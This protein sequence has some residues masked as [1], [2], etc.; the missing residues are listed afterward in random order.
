MQNLDVVSTLLRGQNAVRSFGVA[1]L[2]ACCALPASAQTSDVTPPILVNFSFAPTS[3]DVS[4][5]AQTVA[6]TMQVTDDLSGVSSVSV[7]FRSPNGLQTLSGFAT[8]TAGTAFD[9]VWVANVVIPPFSEAG[10]WTVF[11]VFVQDRVGNSSSANAAVLNSR[12]FPTLLLVNSISDT[13]APAVVGIAVAPVGADVSLADQPIQIG[14]QVTDN[15][16]GVTFAPCTASQSFNF[17]AVILQSPSR[18]QFRYLSASTFTLIAGTAA[19]GT[20]SSTV[21]MPRYSEAGTWTIQSVTVRDCAGNTRFLNQT[22]LAAAGLQIAL[23]V[24]ASPTDVQ[25]PTLTGLAFSPIAINTSTG[26]QSVTVQLA[27]SDALSGA[28]F[29]PTTPQ[30]SFFENGL[31]F[32]SPSGNQVRSAAFFTTFTLI[33][34]TPQNG[35]WQST[36][37][38]PQFSEEGTWT[39]D[40]VSIKDAARNTRTFTTAQLFAAGFPTTLEVT[41][42]SLV[43][44]GTIGAGGG[45]VID[46][47]FGTRARVTLPPGAVTVP[48]QISIDVFLQ[49]LQIPTPAGFSGP[50]TNFVNIQ[51]TPQPNYPLPP[52][53]LTIVLPM[54]NPMPAGSVLMLHKID[55]STGF[56]VRAKDVFN[57]DV[58]GTVDANGLSAT[59]TGIA[60]LSTV[61]GLIPQAL[62]ATLTAGGPTTIR[63]GASFVV[64]TS[65][66]DIVAANGPWRYVLDWGDGTSFVSTLVSLPTPARPITRGKVY[67]APGTYTIR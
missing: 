11:N 2:L 28:R 26:N 60:S 19:N 5:T 30:L 3:I 18:A 47:T 53:G 54:P 34:G 29:S 41:K 62:N 49:P 31:Q 33:S 20:W 35:V 40:N 12:G 22:Q 10:N 56:L 7:N 55:V 50:G 37:F 38:F 4:S 1:L 23:P 25:A 16:S 42:P 17:F 59:F 58:F 27:I 32:R 66:T 39:I 67:G 8:R 45:S 52:P 63:A 65:A 21:T 24:L 44:D 48:T 57:N 14:L 51:L 46:Q 6:V 15:L 64:R 9:G 43:V 13:Q 61:V 36:I